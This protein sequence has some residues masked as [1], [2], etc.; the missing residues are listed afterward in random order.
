MIWERV[1]DRTNDVCK[2]LA[3]IAERF[4]L[5]RASRSKRVGLLLIQER[6]QTL[7]AVGQK[8]RYHAMVIK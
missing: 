7:E 5:F 6:R 1:V 8:L 3:L 4:P 2:I